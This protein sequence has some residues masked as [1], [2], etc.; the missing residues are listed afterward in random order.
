MNIKWK[1]VIIIASSLTILL[2]VIIGVIGFTYFNISRV[3]A[4][5][6]ANTI[7][8]GDT[9]LSI[10]KTDDI[11]RGDIIIFKFPLDM[12]TNYIKRVIGLPGETIEIKNNKVFINGNEL[13]EHLMIVSLAS[14]DATAPLKIIRPGN[15]LNGYTVYLDENDIEGDDNERILMGQKYAVGKPFTISKDHYFVMGDNRSNSQDSRYWG[16]VAKDLLMAKSLMVYSKRTNEWKEL[17]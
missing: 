15:N 13:P 16:E 11:K 9:V 14:T 12:K 8:A 1:K 10:K 17:K 2:I 6:M 3:P 5:S 7:V 4:A